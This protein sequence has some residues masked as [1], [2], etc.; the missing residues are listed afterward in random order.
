LIKL[1]SKSF[2][3]TH[4]NVSD[5]WKKWFFIPEMADQNLGPELKQLDS[6]AYDMLVESRKPDVFMYC[7]KLCFDN[8]TTSLSQ[9]FKKNSSSGGPGNLPNHLMTSHKEAYEEYNPMSAKKEKKGEV[10]PA[11]ISLTMQLPP[12]KPDRNPFR[13][14]Q[15]LL[16]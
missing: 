5:I 16:P 2:K 12:K 11:V 1:I 8:P 9:C 6:T 14:A 10:F 3:R 13:S 15:E 4:S 7:C